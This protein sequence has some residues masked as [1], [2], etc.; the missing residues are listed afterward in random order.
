MVF[1][2]P[3]IIVRWSEGITRGQHVKVERSTSYCILKGK[4]VHRHHL[5]LI[6]IAS[7]EPCMYRLSLPLICL[8]FRS[9][10]TTLTTKTTLLQPVMAPCMF[11][12]K[13][14]HTST[15]L[16]H[17][18]GP[19]FQLHPTPN[20]DSCA[21][22]YTSIS[23][24]CLGRQLNGMHP[25]KNFASFSYGCERLPI[26]REQSRMQRNHVHNRRLGK[27]RVVDDVIGTEKQM[28]DLTQ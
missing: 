7:A 17:L 18:V 21:S 5:I 25:H 24:S 22:A 15:I 9:T 13:S 2:S 27:A 3:R 1:A 6:C 12:T 26:C 14:G 4:L 8:A 28:Y 20:Y 10:S 11:S 19:E 16:L 23:H